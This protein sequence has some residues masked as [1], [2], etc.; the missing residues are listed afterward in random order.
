M[1]SESMP[2]AKNNCFHGSR[3]RDHMYY[4]SYA[5]CMQNMQLCYY[6]NLLEIN[7]RQVINATSF[8][9]KPSK[10]SLDLY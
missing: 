3:N 10:S 6:D 2:Q 9:K 7:N 5:N 4:A 1:T 8:L